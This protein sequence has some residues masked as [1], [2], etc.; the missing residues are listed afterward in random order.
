MDRKTQTKSN[1]ISSY[2][3]SKSIKDFCHF[4]SLH[5]Y[6]YLINADSIIAKILWVMVIVVATGLGIAFLVMNT[7]AYMKASIVTN[8][9]SE[10]STLDVSKLDSP[11]DPFK[12]VT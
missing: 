6:N 2:Q 12:I 4:T 9:E 7:S 5:G 10:T 11:I 1:W 3:M 8:I